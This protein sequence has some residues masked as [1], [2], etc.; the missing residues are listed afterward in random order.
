MFTHFIRRKQD[1]CTTYNGYEYVHIVFHSDRNVLFK[2]FVQQSGQ[3][4]LVKYILT[5]DPYLYLHYVYKLYVA[6]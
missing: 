3:V 6:V 1:S 2:C 5:S 4:G